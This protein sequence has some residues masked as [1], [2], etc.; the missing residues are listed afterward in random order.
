MSRAS[1]NNRSQASRI[2]LME[3]LDI[4][5]KEETYRKGLTD[6]IDLWKSRQSLLEKMG[7]EAGLAVLITNAYGRE[8]N[9]MTIRELILDHMSPVVPED[10]KWSAAV[11]ERLTGFHRGAKYSRHK[12]KFYRYVYNKDEENCR[13][14]H[15]KLQEGELDMIEVAR[16]E[17]AEGNR[18]SY[19][20]NGGEDDHLTKHL[21]GNEE[22]FRQFCD[23][24]Q[25]FH[26]H[27]CEVMSI[28]FK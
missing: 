23:E 26:K 2:N 8:G 21:P 7:E 1:Y 16:E 19:L 18:V 6:F 12:E 13:K 14:Y 3:V 15:E 24:L 11:D 28:R 10:G 25:S 4:I 5:T 27:R 9:N 20:I 22:G 17:H